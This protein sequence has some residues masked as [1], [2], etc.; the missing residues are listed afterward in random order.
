M[1]NS[2]LRKRQNFKEKEIQGTDSIKV[3]LKFV[4]MD[5]PKRNLGYRLR[6]FI[7]SKHVGDK[8]KSWFK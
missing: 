7:C 5:R 8:V 2:N 3:V 4:D 1:L 6:L